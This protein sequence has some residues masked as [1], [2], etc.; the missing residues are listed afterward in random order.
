MAIIIIINYIIWLFCPIVDGLTEAFLWTL[1]ARNP[2]PKNRN[3]AIHKAF[4]AQRTA[5]WVSSIAI[6]FFSCHDW[7]ITIAYGIS[8]ALIF[9]FFHNGIMYETRNVLDGSYKDG[10]FSDPSDTSE[11]EINI[12]YR[13]RLIWAIISMLIFATLIVITWKHGTI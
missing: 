9:P 3:S 6:T 8:I 7:A 12:T 2:M 10:F 5:W 13:L 1:N 4:L 11:A